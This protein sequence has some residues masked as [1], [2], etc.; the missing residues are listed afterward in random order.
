MDR[1]DGRQVD[2]NDYFGIDETVVLPKM[3]QIDR[4]E[5]VIKKGEQNEID[6]IGEYVIPDDSNSNN[7]NSNNQN[8]EPQT[9]AWFVSVRYR[10]QKMGE[11]EVK[12]FIKHA[13]ET[14]GEKQYAV[15]TR[16]Y[17]SKRGFTND[18]IK[19]LQKEGI[20]YN[21]V[22]QFNDLASLFGFLGLKF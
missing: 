3:K 4:R 20:Y 7:L 11:G 19:L 6:V 2:G 17:F 9:G 13:A 12:K 21:D 18:A 16:W 14:Q 10:N 5:G 8:G 15:V 1:F 22:K